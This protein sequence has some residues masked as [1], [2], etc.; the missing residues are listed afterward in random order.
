MFRPNSKSSSD[1]T[2][3]INCKREYIKISFIGIGIYI[4]FNYKIEISIVIRQISVYIYMYLY[5][6]YFIHFV[7][8]DDDV[9]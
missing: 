1:T 9:L 3:C 4:V 8:P 6:L 7:V 2:N 5:I